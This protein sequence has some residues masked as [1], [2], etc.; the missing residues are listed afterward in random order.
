MPR[1]EDDDLTPPPQNHVDA[2]EAPGERRS[3]ERRLETLEWRFREIRSKF[4]TTS[5][6][7]RGLSST[8]DSKLKS[9]ERGQDLILQRLLALEI[10][11]SKADGAWTLLK[12]LGIIAL[13]S[14]IMAIFLGITRMLNG[15]TP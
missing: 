7:V 6:I 4:E 11:A 13:T 14:A 9:F 2:P 15:H 8:M 5:E 10:L 3:V 12:V 1:H